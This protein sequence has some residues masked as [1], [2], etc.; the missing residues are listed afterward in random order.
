MVSASLEGGAT[1]IQRW[2]FRHVSAGT[3]QSTS[4]APLCMQVGKSYFGEQHI[5][6]IRVFQSLIHITKVN[7]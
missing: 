6:P 1:N 3:K 7:K 5:C 2:C 4:T